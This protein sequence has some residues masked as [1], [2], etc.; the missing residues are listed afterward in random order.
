LVITGGRVLQIDE[1]A[2]F[3]LG[4]TCVHL[5]SPGATTSAFLLSRVVESFGAS[6]RLLTFG[7]A[8]LRRVGVGSGRS[9]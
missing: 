2:T 1:G 4:L 6:D 5:T 9:H 7:L 3:G 8:L